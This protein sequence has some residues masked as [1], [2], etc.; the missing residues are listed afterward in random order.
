MKQG[1]VLGRDLW[2][3]KS[4][5]PSSSEHRLAV[6]PQAYRKTVFQDYN[7]VCDNNTISKQHDR[8]TFQPLTYIPSHWLFRQ[9]RG[10]AMAVLFGS[11]VSVA[12]PIAARCW[13]QLGRRGLVQLSLSDNVNWC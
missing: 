4:S 8:V 12:G 11:L 6:R 1:T 2:Y 10:S 7:A 13:P 3:C 5:V 9:D